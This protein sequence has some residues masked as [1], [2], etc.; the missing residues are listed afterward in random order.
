MPADVQKAFQRQIPTRDIAL[1]LTHMEQLLVIN[2][3]DCTHITSCSLPKLIKYHKEPNI[4]FPLT[5]Q[6]R[7]IVLEPLPP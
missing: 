3:Q 1:C 2:Q 4:D 6:G 5:H 7:D